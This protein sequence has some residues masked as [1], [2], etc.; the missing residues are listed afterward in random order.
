MDVVG[1][2]VFSSEFWLLLYRVVV[3]V[4]EWEG[5][6]VV[7][8]EV[9]EFEVVFGYDEVVLG[10]FGVG[11]VV[12]VSIVVFLDCDVDVVC[13]L[14]NVGCIVLWCVGWEVFDEIVSGC[15]LC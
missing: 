3:V 5:R 15:F 9:F 11:V 4:S 12:F 7:V 2:W 1:L 10:I 6:L 8:W 13:M 14:V